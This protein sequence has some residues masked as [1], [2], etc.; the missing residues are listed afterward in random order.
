MIRLLSKR[1]DRLL[2]RF[3][4]FANDKLTNLPIEK[5]MRI[6]KAIKKNDA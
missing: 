1:L 3:F 4:I 5:M 2:Q 6:I